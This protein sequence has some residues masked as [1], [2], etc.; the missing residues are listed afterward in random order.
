MGRHFRAIK[1]SNDPLVQ[2]YNPLPSP[3]EVS[4][5]CR[6]E[7]YWSSNLLFQP[8]TKTQ[9]PPSRPLVNI[10]IADTSYEFAGPGRTRVDLV[11]APNSTASRGSRGATHGS[12]GTATPAARTRNS[13][14]PRPRS[15]SGMAFARPRP[16]LTCLPASTWGL[17]T[18]D[19]VVSLQPNPTYSADS[20]KQ[21]SPLSHPHPLNSIA[22]PSHAY[23]VV[24]KPSLSAGDQKEGITRRDSRAPP[25]PTGIG[26]G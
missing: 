3:D 24:S 11:P 20:P 25:P 6:S 26:S 8:M 17:S 12:K 7:Y 21:P 16:G 4:G 19:R 13:P 1:P 15:C 18:R 23:E 2:A 22:C 14:P 9:C 10:A 5:S